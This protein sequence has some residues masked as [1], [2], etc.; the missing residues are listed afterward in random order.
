LDEADQHDVYHLKH[1]HLKQ[2]QEEVASSSISMTT[3][4]IE[5]FRLSL[6]ELPAIIVVSRF[7]DPLIV[8]THDAATSASLVQFVKA[9][10]EIKLPYFYAQPV[11]EP[12]A[13]TDRQ[14]IEQTAKNIRNCAIA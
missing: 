1:F 10:G 7:R 9:L 8:P 14:A 5:Y 4:L 11:K 3:E 6:D 2:H 13:V 12:R